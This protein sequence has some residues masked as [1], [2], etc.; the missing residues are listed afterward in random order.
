[1]TVC[2]F[3]VGI[4][5][6]AYCIISKQKKNDA[7]DFHI[8]DWNVINISNQDKKEKMTCCFTE[9]CCIGNNKRKY[10]IS[11][12]LLDT[13]E[14]KSPISHGLS[15]TNKHKKSNINNKKCN[16]NC[17]TYFTM[18]DEK[19]SLCKEHISKHKDFVNN[20]Y[21]E[22]I[23]NKDGKDK[24]CEYN[25]KR[26]CKSEFVYLF[27]DKDNV[28]TCLCEKHYNIELKNMCKQHKLN[29]I[30]NLNVN[31][32]S[33]IVL[34]TNMYTK[35]DAIEGLLNV[36]EVLIE[37]QPTLTN[38]IMKNIASLLFGYFVMKGIMTNKIKSVKFISPLNKLKINS[39]ISKDVL[40]QYEK[41]YDIKRATKN[42]GI[43]Y[44]KILLN[45]KEDSL[46][47][48]K[49][50]VKIDDMCDAF[51]Q[52]YHYLFKNEDYHLNYDKYA[53]YI[54]KQK[55]VLD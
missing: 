33:N 17:N 4:K 8:L 27:V 37:N 14:D 54:N 26:Q 51:L 23:N 30:K 39:E 44:T 10:P 20:R 6:L 21:F 32:E 50:H 1:M 16:K 55:I 5:N 19:I 40:S 29:K 15:D 9:S 47:F 46:G 43:V 38:P 35:L 45:D 13:L 11:Y 48:I 24:L 3:D 22:L 36:D 53:K 2:S 41:K 28:K 25:C 18:N 12:G 31:Y 49:E 52:G 42:L 34:A 7:L